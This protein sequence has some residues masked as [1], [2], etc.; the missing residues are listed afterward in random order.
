M[1]LCVYTVLYG[2]TQW[3]EAGRGISASEAGLLLLPMTAISAI[4]MGPISQRNLVRGP[5]IAGAAASLAGAAGVLFLTTS[6]PIIW[7]VVV[8]LIF[9]IALGTAAS[10]NQ[11]ALYTQVAAGQLGTAAGLFRTF[12]YVGSIA[13]S[14]ITGIVF[15]N[16]VSDS[17]V[18]LIGL[19][20]IG[21]SIVA[22]ALSVFDRR[23]RNPGLPTRQA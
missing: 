17:G 1:A 7:I 4:M 10:G 3:I 21:I 5:L 15:H 20:M 11:T 23:L 8:T 14:A 19:I 22:V 18:H 13:S 12:G 9:G 16:S 2:V 6:T